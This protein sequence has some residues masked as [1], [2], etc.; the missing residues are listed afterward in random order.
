MEKEQSNVRMR[1]AQYR[2]RIGKAIRIVRVGQGLSL[3]RAAAEF[4]ITYQ[5]MQKYEKGTN[6]VSACRLGAIADLFDH[7]VESFFGKGKSSLAFDP[8]FIRIWNLYHQVPEEARVKVLS[9][10]EMI[11]DTHSE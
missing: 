6:R 3:E 5:Q 10:I 8:E 9:I 2:A 11:I 7:P 1:E 4:G